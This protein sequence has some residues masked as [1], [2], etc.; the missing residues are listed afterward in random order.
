MTDYEK[1]CHCWK[2][3]D[4]TDKSTLEKYMDNFK[5]LFAYHSGKLENPEITYDDTREIF[6]KDE[7][8]SFTGSLRTIFEIQNQKICYDYLIDK[9]LDKQPLTEDLI[10]RVHKLLARGTYDKRR[11]VDNEERPGVYKTHDYVTGPK[12]VGLPPEEVEDAMKELITQ[13]HENDTSDPIVVAAYLH[14]WFEYIH[15][16]ADGNGRTGRTLMNYYLMTH[17]HPPII[18]Y[19]DEKK[20]YLE[21]LRAFDDEEDLKPLID[22]M[23]NATIRSWNRL[24]KTGS[25][26]IKS[27]GNV[28][29][30]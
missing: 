18:I 26:K 28:H 3:F 22:F 1:I 4:I 23:R 9:S 12:E 15:P 2:S 16:F 25:A 11:Y 6:E 27:L 20:L 8:N 17:G 5:I 30:E 21:A 24:L 7:V 29:S 10:K 13:V 19:D 14:A